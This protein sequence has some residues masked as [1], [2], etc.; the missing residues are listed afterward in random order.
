MENIHF[1]S[2]LFLFVLLSSFCENSNIIYV[3]CKGKI[4]LIRYGGSH[5]IIESKIK[6]GRIASP[7]PENFPNLHFRVMFEWL[8][9]FTFSKFLSLNFKISFSIKIKHL[10]VFIVAGLVYVSLFLLKG[11]HKRKIYEFF[12]TY[13]KT[14]SKNIKE[15]DFS[16]Y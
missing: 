2:T 15:I 5:E 1:L 12:H 9:F 16:C 7:A 13:D 8:Y 11:T 14:Q 4:G 3:F 6:K 10:K